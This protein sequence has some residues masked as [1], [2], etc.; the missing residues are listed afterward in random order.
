M[1]INPSLPQ[2]WTAEQMQ[3]LRFVGYS[4]IQQGKYDVSRTLFE[5]LVAFDQKNAYDVQTLGALYLQLN[6]LKKALSTLDI[7]LIIDSKHSPTLLNRAKT[8]LLLGDVEQGLKIC[9]KLEKNK[10]TSIAN[11]AGALIL[12]YKP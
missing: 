9:R 1:N 2:P 7:A 12:A 8:L 6:D 11:S 4:Y 5:A 3:N 10:D